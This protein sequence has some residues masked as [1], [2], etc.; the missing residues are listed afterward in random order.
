MKF[1]MQFRKYCVLLINKNRHQYWFYET[2]YLN[3]S[4]CNLW[5]TLKELQFFEKNPLYLP[6]RGANFR[7]VSVVRQSVLSE[8]ARSI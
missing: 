5:W 3:P 7:E 8:H 6:E 2:P 1:T 4:I